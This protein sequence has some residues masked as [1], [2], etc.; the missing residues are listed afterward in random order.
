MSISESVDAYEQSTAFFLHEAAAVT[1]DNLNRHVH[2]GWTARQVIHHMADSEA[3]G[4]ARLRRLLAEPEGSVI[5]DYDEAAWAE[6]EQ[7]GYHEL[8]IEHSL[9]VVRVL[10][11][12]SLDV[13]GRLRESDL[14]RYGEHTES[15]RYT[16]AHWLDVYTEHPLAHAAQLREA[17]AA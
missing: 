12:A 14:D 17:L 15:G 1:E 13:L 5:Q 2:G 6:C 7:L 3:E 9:D 10:R 8:A 11:F 16:L 4:H